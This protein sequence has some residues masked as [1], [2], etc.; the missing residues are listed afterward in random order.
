MGKG[1]KKKV[2]KAEEKEAETIKVP[3]R[4]AV[5]GELLTEMWV[6]DTDWVHQA[7]EE[8]LPEL[9]PFNLFHG[10][11]KI[12]PYRT[13]G[14]LG[15]DVVLDLVRLP[16]PKVFLKKNDSRFTDEGF[17]CHDSYLNRAFSEDGDR[18]F[19]TWVRH[20]GG[21][22]WKTYRSTEH[23]T[24]EQ[25]PM[26]QRR[27]E[28]IIAL[29]LA[30]MADPSCKAAEQVTSVLKQWRGPAGD[31]DGIVCDNGPHHLLVVKSDGTQLLWKTGSGGQGSIVT[32]GSIVTSERPRQALYKCTIP[33]FDATDAI[34][35]GESL[36]VL[37][38]S[39]HAGQQETFVLRLCW[40]EDGTL[41]ENSSVR[42]R[43]PDREQRSTL[44]RL[45]ERFVAIQG[46][47]V[48][49]ALHQ[50][51]FTLPLASL[52]HT[53][54]ADGPAKETTP[55]CCLNIMD[56]EAAQLK[57]KPKQKRTSI[58]RYAML[59]P[60]TMNLYIF[61]DHSLDCDT[62]GFD[63]FELEDGDEATPRKYPRQGRTKALR[64]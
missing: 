25:D 52:A 13:L 8:R 47:A 46:E 18:F 20:F 49:M 43:L 6:E 64:A 44:L 36:F 29:D 27:C 22:D 7:A 24:R 2:S 62:Y 1:G 50:G 28:E 12:V 19:V 40:A 33:G 3:V 59:H 39:R 4:S 14:S 48:W 54:L 21:P 56:L 11:E 26:F 60:A 37:G 42:L 41:L 53:D 32:N 63:Y 23:R 16:K 9:K 55:W 57:H 31:H 61:H 10:S 5:S 51:I 30:A 15:S 58:G 38:D 34:S 17:H 45:R 35:D